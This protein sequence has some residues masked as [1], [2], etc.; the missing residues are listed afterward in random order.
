MDNNA[1]PSSVPSDLSAEQVLQVLKPLVHVIAAQFGRNCEVVVHDLRDP[2]HSVVAI[3]NGHVTGRTSGSP[4][5][6]GPV[7]D[8][9]PRLLQSEEQVP[10]HLLSYETT[11]RDGRRL[12]SSTAFYRDAQ[13]QVV[14][15]LCINYDLSSLLV[16][17]ALIADLRGC[18]SAEGSGDSDA[19]ASQR[20][21]VNEVLAQLVQEAIADQGKSI[22]LM[23][24]DDKVAAVQRMYDKGVFLIKGSIDYVANALGVSRY[25]V[26]GYV[27]QIKSKN[28][29]RS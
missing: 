25:T 29:F 22:L 11:T 12:K 4:A 6:G 1:S 2:E 17:E 19:Q 24:R 10:G 8:H 15:A 9:A 27:E 21:D 5:I 3:A 28:N 18:R 23:E 26:Y 16:A 13:G 20:V 14:A 7:G